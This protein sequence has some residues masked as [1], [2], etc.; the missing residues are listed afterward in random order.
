MAEKPEDDELTASDVQW[1]TKREE[2]KAER[3]ALL[4][5]LERRVG[6][7]EGFVHSL[8]SEDDDWSLV[9]KLAVLVE[10]SVTHALVLYVKNEALFDHFAEVSNFKRLQL[11]KKFGILDHLDV[12]A[13]D[14]VAWMRNRFAHNVK[15]L[16]SDLWTF[17][18]AQADDKKAELINKMLKRDG[19]DRMKAADDFNGFKPLLQV[20]VYNAVITALRAIAAHGNEAESAAEQEKWE[21][22]R[23]ADMYAGNGGG[24]EWWHAG[25]GPVVSDTPL[26][27]K[28]AAAAAK[29]KD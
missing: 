24:N 19:K 1:L 6:I 7:P 13:L 26:V 25:S 12:E 20:T 28:M 14:A 9:I 27:L 15:F 3:L 4:A 10:A 17:F 18:D 16:G 22:W 29:P 11:A 23:Q 21:K 8:L 5:T 2:R